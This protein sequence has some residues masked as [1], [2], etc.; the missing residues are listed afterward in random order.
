MQSIN[1]ES[2]NIF[3]IMHR[4]NVPWILDHGLHCK[5][6][7][8]LD[9]DFV[10]IGN[11]DLIQKRTDR[12]ISIPPGGALSDYLPFY[13]TPFS[14]MMY[15]IYTGYGGITKRSNHEIVIFKASLRRLH[16]DGIRFVFSDRHAFLAAAQFSS[17][18][19]ELKRIDWLL[20]Q[21]RDFKRDPDDPEK[22]ERYQAEALI[23]RHLPLESLDGI[24]CFNEAA[25]A[26]IKAEI[27]K[28]GLALKTAQ[29]PGWFF[30]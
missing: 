19:A 22:V 2:A 15:N 1:A 13:F 8:K 21:N 24:V 7:S 5:R 4:S 25:E 17:D 23:H 20:L 26:D 10:E 29:R 30:Q 28:R 14:P 9:S 18:L 11:P 3:R 6:A 27:A 16:A 12:L